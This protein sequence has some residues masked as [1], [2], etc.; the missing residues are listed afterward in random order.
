MDD[1]SDDDVDDVD[2]D[3]DGDKDDDDI[4][5]P[6]G[7]FLLW[8]NNWPRGPTMWSPWVPKVTLEG[9]KGSKMEPLG[10]LGTPWGGVVGP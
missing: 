2:D 8:E 9:S 10:I 7:G 1:D 6:E 3:D 5:S 4:C